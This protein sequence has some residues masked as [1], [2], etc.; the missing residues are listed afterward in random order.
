M[1]TQTLPNC[2]HSVWKPWT[3][4]REDQYYR[5]SDNFSQN[6]ATGIQDQ[7]KSINQDK[8]D[9]SK[10]NLLNVAKMPKNK[11]LEFTSITK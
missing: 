7:D 2:R 8:Y 1:V 10:K 5:P 3:Q 4:T 6:I 9:F 11:F